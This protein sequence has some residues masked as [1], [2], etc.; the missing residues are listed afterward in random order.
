MLSASLGHCFVGVEIDLFVFDRLPEPL[1]EDVVA[2]CALAAIEMAI[3]AFFSTAV[4]SMEVNW[5]DSTGRR[6]TLDDI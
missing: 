4:K 6:N 5:A 1:D 2:P 3:S